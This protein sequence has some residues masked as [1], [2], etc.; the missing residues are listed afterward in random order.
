[1]IHSYPDIYNL[2]HRA[3][4]ELLSGPVVVQEKVDGSQLSFSVVNGVLEFRS[5]GREFFAATA[6]KMFVPAVETVVA[7]ADKLIP[8]AIYR[9]EAL[10]KPKHN[11]LA[12]ARVPIGGIVLFDV[13]FS[14]QHYVVPEELA[15]IAKSLG[16]EAVPLFHRGNISAEQ[17]EALLSLTSFLGGTKI[18]GVV[19]KNYARFTTDKKVMMGKYVSEVFKETHKIEWKAGPDFMTTVVNSLRTEARWQKSVQ[20]LRDDGKLEGSPRDIGP[21]IRAVLDDVLKEEQESLKDILF[22]HYWKEIAK[23]LSSG[24][25]GWYKEQLREAK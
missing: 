1:M 4:E 7:I 2:G 24:F 15:D 3:V 21:L 17:I 23:G 9:G 16:L 19:I 11:V 25:P 10:S 12:Y 18:E 20:H 13:E 14:G 6:D 22:K 8:N 5:K